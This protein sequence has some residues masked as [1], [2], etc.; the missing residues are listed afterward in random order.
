M[1]HYGTMGF[2]LVAAPPIMPTDRYRQVLLRVLEDCFQ[3]KAHHE[4][5]VVPIYELEIADNGPKMHPDP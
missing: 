2:R 3:L 1:G 5:M 4:T